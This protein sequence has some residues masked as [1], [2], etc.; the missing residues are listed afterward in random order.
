MDV[1]RDT[2][3][4]LLPKLV[5]AGLVSVAVFGLVWLAFVYRRDAY[6][7]LAPW[8]ARIGIGTGKSGG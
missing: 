5:A 3:L 6:L 2:G 7:D 4:R 1:R 8:L